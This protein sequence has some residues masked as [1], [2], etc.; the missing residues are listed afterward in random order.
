M[1]RILL[2]LALVAP[3]VGWGQMLNG[4]DIGK[5][6]DLKYIE[7]VV[8]KAPMSKNYFAK[9]DIGQGLKMSDKG[10]QDDAGEGIDFK[11][12]MHVLN[13]LWVRGWDLVRDWQEGEVRHFLMERAAEG[14]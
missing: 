5:M 3:C 12:D 14:K 9:A 10:F 6:T 13:W 1:K 4:V 2:F 7:V 11:S 8:S